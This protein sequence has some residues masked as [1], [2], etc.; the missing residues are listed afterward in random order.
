MVL[1][2]NVIVPRFLVESIPILIWMITE[3]SHLDN[4][5]A[6][7]LDLGPESKNKLRELQRNFDMKLQAE[8]S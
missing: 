6:D 1:D 7:G 4:I 3:I 2:F 5:V 8:L